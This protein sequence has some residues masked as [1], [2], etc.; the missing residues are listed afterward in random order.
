MRI[1]ALAFPQPA[2]TLTTIATHMCALPLVLTETRRAEVV[3]NLFQPM[4][5]LIE[6]LQLV[7]KAGPDEEAVLMQFIGA[8]HAQS[9]LS[10]RNEQFQNLLDKLQV[11]R[12]AGD[13]SS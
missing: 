9:E 3:R 13:R 10:K 12:P 11:Y 5:L 7:A 2:D 4:L 1:S 8:V 6:A